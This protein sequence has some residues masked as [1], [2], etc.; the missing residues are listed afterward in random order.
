MFLLEFYNNIINF[1]NTFKDIMAKYYHSTMSCSQFHNYK[2]YFRVKEYDST[3]YI[4]MY[5]FID[6]FDLFK[7]NKY[8]FKDMIKKCYLS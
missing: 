1:I 2:H 6:Y 4:Y 5:Y 8:N 3:F 7:D